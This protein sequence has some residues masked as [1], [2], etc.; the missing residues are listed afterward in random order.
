MTLCKGTWGT[1]EGATEGGGDKLA[2]RGGRSWS[3]S[4]FQLS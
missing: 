4:E 3:R 2:S 1:V